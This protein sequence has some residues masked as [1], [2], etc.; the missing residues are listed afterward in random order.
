LLGLAPTPRNRGLLSLRAVNSLKNVFGANWA[1]SLM[2]RTPSASRVS[3]VTAVTLTGKSAV[4]G[5]FCAVT[6]TVGSLNRTV[7]SSGLFWPG[8]GCC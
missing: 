3:L 1:A 8:A 2:L 7:P 4:L 5:L 6:E